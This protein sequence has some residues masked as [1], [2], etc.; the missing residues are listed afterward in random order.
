MA[1][2]FLEVKYKCVGDKPESLINIK[3]EFRAINENWRR[4]C[5]EIEIYNDNGSWQSG[6]I[7]RNVST[8]KKTTDKAPV[9]SLS[10]YSYIPATLA[11]LLF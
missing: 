10:E 8:T 6:K 3:F 2:N 1:Y 9:P 4:N 5:F 11:E 7:E